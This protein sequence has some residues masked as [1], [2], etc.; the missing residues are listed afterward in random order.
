MTAP[1]AR[2]VFSEVT[3]SRILY[4]EPVSTQDAATGI[5]LQYRFEEH[6]GGKLRM[7]GGHLR[8]RVIA[9][10]CEPEEL[11]LVATLLLDGLKAQPA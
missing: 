9:V 1:R 10:G 3:L 8:H 7:T 2:P 11:N 6:A 5:M 4:D